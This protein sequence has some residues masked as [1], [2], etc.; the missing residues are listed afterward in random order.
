M[1]SNKTPLWYPDHP[2][3]YDIE[4]T[5]LENAEKGP[6]F[7]GPLPKRTMPP[8]EKWIDFLGIPIASPIGIPAGPLLNARWIA[9]AAA[10][11]FDVLTYKTIRSG[12]HPSHPLPNMIYVDTQGMLS[13][14][15]A[16]KAAV[17]TPFP[18]P[19]IEDLAVTNSFGMPSRSP[20]YLLEDIPRAQASLQKGQ[21]MIV[22]VVGTP[23][24]DHKF[25][26]DFVAAA[27]LA[28]DAGALKSS[29]PI[30]RAPMSIRRTV[31]F[32]PLCMP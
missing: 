2:P 30:S 6:F 17:S 23:R 13:K 18:S 29:R 4:K 15:N 24:P 31:F 21:A 12:E 19:R 22:S 11:G 8:K 9:L 28:K 7:N 1:L 25:L 16:L 3:L 5:Y 20:A 32:T 10:L 27:R 26:E 14:E